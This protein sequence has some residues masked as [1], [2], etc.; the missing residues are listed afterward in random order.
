MVAEGTRQVLMPQY[1]RRFKCIGPQCEDNCC[2]G[3]RVV[4]LVNHVFK[5]LFPFDQPT[6]F[7]SYI[8]LVVHYAMIKLQLIGIAIFHK[9]LT[10]EVVAKLI[11]SFAKTVEHNA[12][13]LQQVLKLLNSNGYNTMPWIA[14]MI[15][16]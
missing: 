12:A 13:Y 3:W 14:I 2:V 6:V 15:K 9:G 1:M 7:E 10:P 4:V 8:M 11:Q 5:N 16:N